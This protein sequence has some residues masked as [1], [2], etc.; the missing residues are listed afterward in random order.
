LEVGDVVAKTRKGAHTTTI[1]KLVPLEFGGY[2]IDTPGIKSFGVWDLKKNE[3]E[4]HFP[5]ILEQGHQCRFP[6]CS[7]VHEVECAVKEA[8]EEGSISPLRYESYC[9]LLA[10]ADE[11]YLRR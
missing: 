8:V 4:A 10:N 1:T 7:H 2:C 3:I 6:D 9:A 5:E 11:D